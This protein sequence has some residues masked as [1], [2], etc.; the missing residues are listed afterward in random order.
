MIQRAGRIAFC[1]IER[2]C[3][4]AKRRFGE[5]EKISVSLHSG[6][7]CLNCLIALEIRI[8]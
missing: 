2:H 4:P 7:L 5:D 8:A 6:F 1:C 3:E